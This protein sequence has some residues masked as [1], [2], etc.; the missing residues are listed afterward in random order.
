MPD[1]MV[2][3]QR[4]KL[5]LSGAALLEFVQ[6]PR[7]AIIRKVSKTPSPVVATAANSGRP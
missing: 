2:N 7:R 3:K 5:N 1:I 4:G 6:E